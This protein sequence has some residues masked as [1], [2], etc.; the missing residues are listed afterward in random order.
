M[1]TIYIKSKHV[2]H[3]INILCNDVNYSENDIN[4]PVKENLITD[5]I[6][7][8]RQPRYKDKLLR[9]IDNLTTYESKVEYLNNLYL[10]TASREHESIILDLL[11]GLKQWD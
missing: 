9:K 1:P 6:R 5:I 7:T 8:L 11:K 4:I 10:K 3:L 2:E